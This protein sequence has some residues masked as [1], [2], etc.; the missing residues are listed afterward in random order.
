MVSFL[1]GGIKRNGASIASEKI[2]EKMIGK[3]YKANILMIK[4]V[5]KIHT[6]VC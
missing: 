3:L 5:F 1:S 4:F 6:F 2:F